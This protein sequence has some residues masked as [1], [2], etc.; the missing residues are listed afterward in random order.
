M[1]EQIVYGL[2]AVA[3]LLKNPRRS[4]NKLVVSQ[5]RSDKKLQQLLDQT[6]FTIE[7]MPLSQMNQRFA[8]F[9]HQGVV[10]YTQ[11]LPAYG[12]ADLLHLLETAQQPA[13]VLIL[14]GVTDPHNLGACLRSADAAG[15]DFVVIPKDK[16][17][18]LSP[19]VSKVACGAAEAVPLVRV[20][21][22]VRAMEILK[23]AVFGFTERLV[24]RQLHYI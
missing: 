18:S 13:L 16:S 17:A 11:P 6:H 14:D 24:R 9:N 1:S 19:V 22:L 21:N 15:V 4:I 10:A 5:D 23:E 12:E 7:R 8:D 20:T 3:A 2:H